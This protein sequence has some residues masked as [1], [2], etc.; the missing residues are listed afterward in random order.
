MSEAEGGVR[1]PAAAA[2]R[3]GWTYPGLDLWR[4]VAALW[5]VLLHATQGALEHHPELS[6]DPFVAFS[7]LGYL[8]VEMFFVISGYCIAAAAAGSI[9]RGQS[10]GQFFWARARRIYPPYWAACLVLVAVGVAL[11]TVATQGWVPAE[12]LQSPLVGVV[13]AHSGIRYILANATLAQIVVGEA[14]ICMIAWT[15]CYELAFY[16]VCGGARALVGR[17]GLPVFLAVLHAVTVGSALAMLVTAL[18]GTVMPFPLDMWPMFGLGILAFDIL[19]KE[20]G[21]ASG[22]VWL[23]WAGLGATALLLAGFALTPGADVGFLHHNAG[24]SVGISVAFTLVLIALRRK[25]EAIT[26]SRPVRALMKVGLFSYSLY[27]T[28]FI[29]VQAASAMLRVAHVPHR[30]YGVQVALTLALAIPFAWGFFQLFE[31]PFLKKKGGVAGGDVRKPAAAAAAVARPAASA[32]VPIT[33]AAPT[34]A[35]KEVPSA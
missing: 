10:V 21:T 1:P 27:L 11:K 35:A 33:T 32:V 34:A 26:A 14:F 3:G 2:R 19:R 28:H 15:L 18:T 9:V 6:G 8:G 5:V 24:W 17:Y 4:G 25:D 7:S 16:F 29:W 31:K 30:A 22:S 12:A 13:Y 20:P 23:P